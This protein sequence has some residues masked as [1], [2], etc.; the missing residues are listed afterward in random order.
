MPTPPNPIV[1]FHAARRLR[2][3]ARLAAAQ[4]T[5]RALAGDDAAWAAVDAAI[6]EIRAARAAMDDSVYAAAAA[7][8]G[9][10]GPPPRPTAP[11]A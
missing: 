6:P 11:D 1:R 4:A 9:L 3:A 8:A 10:D 2:N 7:M 5:A